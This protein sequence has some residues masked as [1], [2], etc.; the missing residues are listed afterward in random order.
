MLLKVTL[1]TRVSQLSS[2]PKAWQ[3]DSCGQNKDFFVHKER[4]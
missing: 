2:N 1:S 3:L 4:V